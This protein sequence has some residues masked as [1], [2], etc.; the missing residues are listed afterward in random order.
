MFTSWK[1]TS[2]LEFWSKNQ[3]TCQVNLLVFYKLVTIFKESAR[4]DA[5]AVSSC[6][7][8]MQLLQEENACDMSS[9][10]RGCEQSTVEVRRVMKYSAV[11]A[12]AVVFSFPIEHRA[13]Q[14]VLPRI[15]ASI[16]GIYPD[17]FLENLA[18]SS[19]T[20]TVVRTSEYTVVKK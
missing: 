8:G 9:K 7:A 13:L 4:Q 5:R 17:R 16:D 12:A 20:S 10:D 1:Q 11:L 14:S 2:Y 18:S 19:F 6:K 3:Q 15:R